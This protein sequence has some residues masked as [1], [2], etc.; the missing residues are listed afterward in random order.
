MAESYYASV[1]GSDEEERQEGTG[2][3]PLFQSIAQQFAV[4]G[5]DFNT[6]FR[7][8]DNVPAHENCLQYRQR[9]LEVKVTARVSATR[10]RK[11]YMTVE[12]HGLEQP[13]AYLS[14]CAGSYRAALPFRVREGRRGSS[15]PA[16]AEMVRG[17]RREGEVVEVTGG[18][19]EATPKS[20]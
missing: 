7:I 10:R 5:I 6:P 3:E 16:K 12:P 8:F 18:S 2:S 9:T 4:A 17:E 11:E 1:L 15:T 20:S 13:L 19:L 14:G